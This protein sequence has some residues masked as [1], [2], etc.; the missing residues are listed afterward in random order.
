MN[1]NNHIKH[2][3]YKAPEQV[4]IVGMS[5]H[6]NYWRFKYSACMVTDTSYLRNPNYHKKT[7][8]IDTLN[9]PKMKAV[10]DAVFESII[11]LS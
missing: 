7:D 4:D 1:T 6:F 3:Y 11:S 9:L 5:D 10:I 2:H 8:T